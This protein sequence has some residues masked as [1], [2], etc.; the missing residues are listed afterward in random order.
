MVTVGSGRIGTQSYHYEDTSTSEP[1]ETTR[2]L[3]EGARIADETEE[4][5]I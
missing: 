2:L 4:I 5:G 1:R 3:V